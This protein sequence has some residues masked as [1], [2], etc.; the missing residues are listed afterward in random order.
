MPRIPASHRPATPEP[1][2][3]PD[4]S[5]QVAVL[6][7][8]QPPPVP[9]EPHPP[10][11]SVDRH[12]REIE[13]AEKLLIRQQA[14]ETLAPSEASFLDWLFPTDAAMFTQRSRVAKLLRLQRA[15]GTATDR[16]QAWATAKDAASALEKKG[17]ELH[18]EIAR[19]QADLAELERAAEQSTALV[20]KHET[21]MLA[22]ADP[23]HLDDVTRGRFEHLRKKWEA[24]YG[25]PA[26]TA[27][28]EGQGMIDIAALDPVVDAPKILAYCGSHR[29]LSHVANVRITEGSHRPIAVFE[30]RSGDGE[31]GSR[32]YVVRDQRIVT[33]DAVSWGQFASELRVAGERKLQ[34]AE[35][36]ESAGSAMLAE[37]DQML[38]S[39]VPA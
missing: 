6:E 35:E 20:E 28:A 22:L 5:G 27:R 14:G 36:L 29:G 21:A 7:R 1:I 10:L 13:D 31:T 32:P 34:E 17:P 2:A 12:A 30:R 25:S 38:S 4:Q 11:E 39:L 33:I 24:N 9:T 18:A 19:A 3:E 8:L 15:A 16:E 37:L 23:V 26:R